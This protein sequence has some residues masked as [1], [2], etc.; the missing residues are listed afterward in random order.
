MDVN[1]TNKNGSGA[2]IGAIIVIVV[3]IAG[4]FYFYTQRINKQRQF[5]AMKNTVTQSTSVTKDIDSLLIEA[6]STDLNN[7]GDG[8]ENL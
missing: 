1:N 2:I 4:G 5:E 8:I 3:L 7:L 6:S